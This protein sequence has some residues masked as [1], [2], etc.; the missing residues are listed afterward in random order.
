MIHGVTCA[1]SKFVLLWIFDGDCHPS[2]SK[3]MKNDTSIKL[4]YLT[5]SLK[6]PADFTIWEINKINFPFITSNYNL[7]RPNRIKSIIVSINQ[8]FTDMK[9][10]YACK[11]KDRPEKSHL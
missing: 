6:S 8:V 9:A 2:I 10:D 3:S 4:S 5:T 7:K 1:S 11:T